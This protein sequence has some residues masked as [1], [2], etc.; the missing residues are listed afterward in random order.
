MK[1][2]KFYQ[3]IKVTLWK[4]QSF[5]ISADTEEE[6]I[7]EAERYKTEDVTAYNNNVKCTDLTETEEFMHPIEND[8][9]H[10]IELYSKCGNKFLGENGP[11][12]TN[13]VP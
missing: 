1:E 12:D 3:D 9:Q 11:S 4:R 13:P 2:F 7:Q 10:T 6:A 5:C 8:G